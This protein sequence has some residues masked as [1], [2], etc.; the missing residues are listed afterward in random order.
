[1]PKN[2]KGDH[3]T[4]VALLECVAKLLET[5]QSDE[6]SVDMVCKT[7]GIALGS[8]YHHFQDLPNLIDQAL[9]FR[10]ARYVD[11][12]IEWL[13]Q[14]LTNSQ[15]K[16]EFFEG[17]KRVT[18]GTQTKELEQVRRER[19]GAIYRTG[20][21]SAFAE[22]LGLEQQRLTDEIANVVSTAQANGWVHPGLDPIAASVLIQAYSLGRIVDDIS[23]SPMDNDKWVEIID[24]LAEKVFGLDD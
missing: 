7:S 11:R 23:P 18:R 13:N 10:F 4:K 22:A 15:S 24:R 1:V 9:V 2:P 20:T 3:P 19:A 8:L 17:L 21:H 12:S 6:I 16:Q 5:N 14:A